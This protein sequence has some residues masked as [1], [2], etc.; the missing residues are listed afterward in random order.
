VLGQLDDLLA[1]PAEDC[2]LSEPARRELP[3][4]RDVGAW[5]GAVVAA[6]RDEIYPAFDRYRRTLRE[7]VLPRARSDDRPGILFVEGGEAAYRAAIRR[8]V[9]LELPPEAIHAI[10]IEEVARIRAETSGLGLRVFGT[11]DLAEIQRRLRT[12]PALHFTT[13]AEVEAAAR[14][15][16]ERAEAVVARCFRRLPRARC[17]VV[18]VPAH[19]ERDTTIAYY[20]EPALDGSRPGRYYI[21][22]SEPQTRPRYDAEALAFHEAVPGHHTQ[23]A[24]AQELEGIPALRRHFGATAFVEGWAL[25]AERLADELDLYAGDVDRLGMLSFDA[26]RASRLVIDTG[27]HALGWTRRQAIDYLVQNTLLAENNAVNEVDRYIAWPGQALAYKLGQRELMRY[28]A[29]SQAALGDRF[30]LAEFH[31][32]LLENGALPLALLSRRVDA[33]LALETAVR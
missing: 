32:R 29:R 13:R 4:A 9:S 5:R 6:V 3:G 17:E 14:A 12:D 33:W 25:Y 20:R 7:S 16:L 1:M 26:W 19:E 8:H 2:A 27:I 15:A 21:N 31:Q 11:G 23:I 10:G 28:R 18:R 30:D 22:T 24:L